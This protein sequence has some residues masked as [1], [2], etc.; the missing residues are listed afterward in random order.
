MTKIE[1]K[2]Q[3]KKIWYFF[4]QKQGTK[5]ILVILSP[6]LCVKKPDVGMEGLK[7]LHR[8]WC[9]H[10]GSA[11]LQC[12][13]AYCYPSLIVGCLTIGGPAFFMCVGRISCVCKIRNSKFSFLLVW[14]LKL[15]RLGGKRNKKKQVWN[16]G[17]DTKLGFSGLPVRILRLG[18]HGK[19]K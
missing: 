12:M 14:G 15:H 13:S 16:G 7:S 8:D 17:K 9:M 6:M 19:N 3:L 4:G 10:Q 11:L 5:P 2:L 1:K 18:R